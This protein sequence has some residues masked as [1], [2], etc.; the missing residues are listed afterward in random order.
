MAT[1][2]EQIE[3]HLYRRQ[4]QTSLG[5]WRTLY[6]ARFK[7]RLKG[8][9]RLFPIGADLKGARDALKKLEARNVDREDFDRAKAQESDDRNKALTLSEWGKH[10]FAEKINRNKRS[11][12]WY[13]AMFENLKGRLGGMALADI[14]EEVIDDYKIRRAQDPIVRHGK[15][16]KSGETMSFASVNRE[17]A[18]L[19]ILL[20]LA[21]RYRKIGAVPEFNL[22]SE[23]S[24]KRTRVASADE[25]KALC[26][27]MP[28]HALRA[29]AGLYETA[30]RHKELLNL[31]W[32]RI[33]ER[34]GVIRFRTEDVKEKK[35]RVTPIS[36]LLAEILAELK[37]EQKRVACITNHVFTKNGKP[38]KSIRK[39]FETARRKA[40]IA[41]LRI[42]DLR[43]TCITRWELE[44]VPSYA[45]MEASGHHTLEMHNRYVNV[46]EQQVRAAFVATTWRR[47]KLLDSPASAS[48]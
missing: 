16:V 2:F 46:N 41:D 14:D 5:E 20:R 44:G 38:I 40:K 42:H 47:G 33:D 25:F 45:I 13:E 37:A 10:C 17:L 35:P 6:Y 32:D 26:D 36:P 15:A 12:D 18:V 1:E 29:L 9:R 31:T 24:R 4:Y 39:P 23:K 22:E 27:N 34:E 21:K 30:A 43:H 28:R 3:T 7:C 48:Y 11:Y 19:R 8:K